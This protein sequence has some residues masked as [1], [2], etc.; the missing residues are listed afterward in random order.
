MLYHIPDLQAAIREV[1][2]VL[3]PSGRFHAATN[4]VGNLREIRTL[5]IG[6]ATTAKTRMST[7]SLE[8]GKGILSERFARTLPHP[9][10]DSLDGTGP[11]DL[12]AHILSAAPKVDATP[13]AG[14][15]L[16]V[17]V[18]EQFSLD[19]GT[20]HVT[21]NTGMFEAWEPMPL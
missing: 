3:K 17:R 21:K 6:F 8:N 15:E 7:F 2:R 12:E 14:L 11:A 13:K 10:D 19:S 20:F 16:P 1:S 4:G 5:S 18:R 9:Y